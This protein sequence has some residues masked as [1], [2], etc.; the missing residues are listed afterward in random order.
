MAS[1]KKAAASFVVAI[2]HLTGFGEGDTV[3]AE[4]LEDVGLNADVL[5]QAGAIRPQPKKEEEV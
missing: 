4:Q 5:V 2:G 1:R 3:T